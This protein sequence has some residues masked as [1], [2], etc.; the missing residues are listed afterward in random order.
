MVENSKDNINIGKNRK[1]YRRLFQKNNSCD[2][3]RTC[4][5]TVYNMGLK[6]GKAL[7]AKNIIDFINK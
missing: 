1:I 7:V 4:L 2:M 5:E 3:L 6:E